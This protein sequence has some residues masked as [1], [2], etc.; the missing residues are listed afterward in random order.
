MTPLLHPPTDG[1]KE[2]LE[3]SDRGLDRGLQRCEKFVRGGII[4]SR[5]KFA[6]TIA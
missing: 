4:E 3:S 5:R 1:S 2:W 6:K